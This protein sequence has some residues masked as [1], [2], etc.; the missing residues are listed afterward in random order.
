MESVYKEKNC[1]QIYHLKQF[2]HK[3]V[4]FGFYSNSA[5]EIFTKPPG[6]FRSMQKD[7]WGT[8]LIYLVIF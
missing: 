2:K 8:I 4:A 6:C 7:L 5:T 1:Y 3:F